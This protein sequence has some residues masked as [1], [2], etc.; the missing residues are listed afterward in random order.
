MLAP[1]RVGVLATLILLPLGLLVG[2]AGTDGTADNS[3]SPAATI[4]S[5]EAASKGLPSR[6]T[7]HELQVIRAALRSA[8]R[9]GHAGGRQLDPSIITAVRNSLASNPSIMN[10]ASRVVLLWVSP[11]TVY[12]PTATRR[13]VTV[14]VWAEGPDMIAAG[15]VAPGFSE[16]VVSLARP[17]RGDAWRIDGIGGM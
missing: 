12:R 10:G 7:A 13:N 1:V 11:R 5:P 8:Y 17:S 16:T 6:V 4:A 9:Q 14:Y 15:S 3:P 2:C